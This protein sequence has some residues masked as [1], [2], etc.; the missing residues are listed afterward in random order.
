MQPPLIDTDARS[1]H[2]E[3]EP[4]T[5][6]TVE[7]DA[8]ASIRG[9]SRAAA[10]RVARF[11]ATIVFAL[12]W[13]PL[14]IGLGTIA[15][16]APLLLPSAL[17]LL[18]EPIHL[19]MTRIVSDLWHHSL[20]TPLLAH[21]E[22]ALSPTPYALLY[23]LGGL[24]TPLL[25]VLYAHKA[26]LVFYVCSY[27]VVAALFL[28]VLG[29][30]TW[31]ALLTLCLPFGNT[32]GLGFHSSNLGSALGLWSCLFL[33]LLA[34]NPTVV[35]A[36]S[37]ALALGLAFAAHPAAAALPGIFTLALFGMHIRRV[38]A[39]TAMLLAWTPVFGWL[40]Y[41]LKT[42][43][44]EPR[45][46]TVLNDFAPFDEALQHLPSSAFG[47]LTGAAPVV[48]L[49][50]LGA[51]MFA[52]VAARISARTS[53]HAQLSPGVPVRKS[54]S[55]WLLG[56]AV[57]MVGLYFVVP[58]FSSFPTPWW[59]VNDRVTGT[60]LFF[61]VLALPRIPRRAAQFAVLPGTVASLFFLSALVSTYLSFNRD[62]EPGFRFLSATPPGSRT[63]ML[64]FP[65]GEVRG[66]PH[67]PYRNVSA[68]MTAT[69]AI[70]DEAIWRYAHAPQARISQWP[71]P[72]VVSPA[73]LPDK[74]FDF[75]DTIIVRNA[76]RR[77]K[78]KLASHHWVLVAEE[79]AW[80][81]Y[82]SQEL[83]LSDEQMAVLTQSVPVELA[84]AIW[85]AGDET[86]GPIADG[87]R[88]VESGE[89]ED[90]A[91]FIRPTTKPSPSDPTYELPFL[92]TL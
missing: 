26:I 66:L 77:M 51:S 46:A 76:S 80:R 87:F 37:A 63:L 79:Q 1:A 62:N 58:R 52:A 5:A 3:S 2:T 47:A 40:W 55:G 75:F 88:D 39:L 71:S 78:T 48:V 35:R 33:F 65:P 7:R 54:E 84:D 74:A 61:A 50:A 73:R 20:S 59:A 68:W 57:L 36:V 82:R 15:V 67:D 16:S 34:R 70:P 27:P 44:T 91:L 64:T 30:P 19:G 12:N 22:L 10:A 56:C 13:A 28:R 53:E 86:S 83:N 9:V 43:S 41:T 6:S 23:A 25:G 89:G 24:L 45:P 42:W 21:Y 11:F 4:R 38:R 32:F 72:P 18:D 85:A 69:R 60:A 81:Y 8:G 29:K 17:P 90:D 92:K 49:G 14:W 31:F